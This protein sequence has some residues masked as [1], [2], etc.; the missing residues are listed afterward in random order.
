MN[1]SRHILVVDDDAEFAEMVAQAVR[2]VSD[3]FQVRV[4]TDSKAAIAEIQTAQTAARSY[5]LVIT[6]IKMPGSSGLQLL[7]TLADIAPRTKTITMTAFHSPELA[8]LA[9]QLRVHAYLIKPI[10]LS[11]FR[12]V[13]HA[14]LPSTPAGAQAPSLRGELP[15]EQKAAIER[16]LANLRAITNSRTALIA[17]I[18]GTVLAID[19]L[20]PHTDIDALCETLIDSM[21][22]V[23]QAMRHAFNTEAPIQQSYYGT[24]AFSICMYRMDS[25]HVIVTVF[26]PAVREG[27]VWYCIRE[28]ATELAGVLSSQTQSETPLR[29][30]TGGDWRT[31]IEQF[32]TGKPAG[33]TRSRRTARASDANAGGNAPAAGSAADRPAPPRIEADPSLSPVGAEPARPSL[34][35]LDWEVP[36]DKN[37][38]PA[39]TETSD[40]FEGIG[41]RE[42]Q[43]RGLYTP[44]A[45]GTDTAENAE[46]PSVEDIDWGVSVDLDWD[47]LVAN[48]DQGFAGMDFEEAKRRGLIGDVE[49][50]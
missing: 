37:W 7:E 39:I 44:Q 49:P 2:D 10:A 23:A 14:A 12:Q 13:V 21:R 9:Q 26:G 42:A 19:S 1:D 20:E 30:Q 46:R 33:R 17:H 29:D 45:P 15:A 50:D 41:L 34:D 22:A 35:Q 11:E 38:E 32:F 36:T 4:S 48:T 28:A 31:R 47:N 24:E 43:D 27:H 25:S 6:D 16:R 3:T 8:A 5:D 18:D 40:A